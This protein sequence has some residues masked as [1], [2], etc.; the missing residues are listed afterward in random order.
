[1]SK[2]ALLP[3]GFQALVFFLGTNGIGLD[4]QLDWQAASV[5]FQRHSGLCGTV[6]YARETNRVTT[7]APFQTIRVQPM[8]CSPLKKSH[9]E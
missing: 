6:D 9:G 7:T 4:F 8:A 3:R 2:I 5:Y 1:M